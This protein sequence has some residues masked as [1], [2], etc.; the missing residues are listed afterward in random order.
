MR[1]RCGQCPGAAILFRLRKRPPAAAAIRLSIHDVCARGALGN[2]RLTLGRKTAVAAAVVLLLLVSAGCSNRP[3]SEA[4]PTEAET[5]EAYFDTP[6]IFNAVASRI[7][8]GITRRALAR[9]LTESAIEV[10]DGSGRHCRVYP[11]NGTQGRDEYGSPVAA[12][13]WFCFGSNGRLERTRR[14]P[15]DS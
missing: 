11:L 3:G 7:P 15:R 6:L 2:R 4:R 5:R 12:E 10:E 13:V 14:F 8:L 9:E 1:R